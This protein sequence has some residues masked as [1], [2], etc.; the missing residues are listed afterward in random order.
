VGSAPDAYSLQ[1]LWRYAVFTV[2]NKNTGEISTTLDFHLREEL[3]RKFRAA[4]MRGE[5]LCIKCRQVVIL[6][7]SNEVCPHFFHQQ[8]STCP[9]ANLSLYHLEARAALYSHLRREFHGDVHMENNLSHSAVPRSVDC[10]VEHKGNTFAY[11][12]FDK[13][14]KN[15][16]QR[17]ALRNALTRNNVQCNFVF[18][19]RMLQTLGSGEGVVQPS[20]TEKFAKLCT[21]FD[22][23]NE[24]KE[25]GSLQ[26]IG[27][28]EQRPVLISYRCLIGDNRSKTFSGI[29]KK[30]PLAETEICTQTG[31][32]VHPEE[33]RYSEI[34][35]TRQDR[36]RI[37]EEPDDAQ[38]L[39]RQKQ[40]EE[41]EKLPRSGKTL[42]E[43]M[44]SLLRPR[45]DMPSIRLHREREAPCEFC[46]DVT[47]DWIVFNGKTGFCKCRKCYEQKAAER[48]NQQHGSTDATVEEKGVQ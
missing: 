22:V 9:E 46:G 25:G 40:R 13:D 36:Q 7:R 19:T 32:L 45:E 33:K 23:L 38:K 35:R 27:I 15:D 16:L 5:L 48:W 20:G 1:S 10:W 12:I 18:T 41:I 30:T 4:G 34:L 47:R 11:W 24:K 43:M 6:H 39:K 3:E 21:P 28:E 44:R 26:Y 17:A 29:R 14:I 8:D 2:V 37:A 42:R 31:F